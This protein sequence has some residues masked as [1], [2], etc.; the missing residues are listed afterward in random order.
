MDDGEESG[1]T[2]IMGYIRSLGLYSIG[3]IWG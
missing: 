2:T 3:V 1:E